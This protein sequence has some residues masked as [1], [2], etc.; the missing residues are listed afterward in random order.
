MYQEIELVITAPS[1]GAR[2]TLDYDDFAGLISILDDKDEFTKEL[3]RE[4]EKIRIMREDED[5]V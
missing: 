3:I 1:T 4:H 2:W 5:E